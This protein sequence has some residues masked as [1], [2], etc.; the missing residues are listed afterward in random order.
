MSQRET[1]AKL[2]QELRVE[3]GSGKAK[4]RIDATVKLAGENPSGWDLQKLERIAQSLRAK[5]QRAE[6][7][8]ERDGWHTAEYPHELC[9]K[10]TE[11][12]P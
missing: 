4:K 7:N 9:R 8:H 12:T 6:E 11:A 5:R 10:C 2:A 3:F 1:F